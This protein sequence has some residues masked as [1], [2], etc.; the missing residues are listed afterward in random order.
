[1][2]I[3]VRDF[4]SATRLT[5]FIEEGRLLAEERRFQWNIFLVW[6]H[7]RGGY[8]Q[9]LF[10]DDLWAVVLDLVCVAFVVWVASG[11]Y[12]WW[13]LR[14]SRFWGAAALVGGVLC[15]GWFLWAL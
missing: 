14:Q 3:F 8:Q 12:M 15:F 2:N 1:M 13:K 11:L 7:I 9:D 10:L 6:I 4:I 5:Y